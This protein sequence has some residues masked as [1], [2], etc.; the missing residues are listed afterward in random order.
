MLGSMFA[1]LTPMALARANDGALLYRCF[2]TVHS[3][4][5]SSID[6]SCEG[7]SKNGTLGC[8]HA[9]GEIP[10]VRC[11][12]GKD[13]LCAER[14]CDKGY[15]QETV[16]GNLYDMAPAADGIRLYRCRIS[17]GLFRLV[18]PEKDIVITSRQVNLRS[19]R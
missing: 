5:F 18:R 3:D 19:Y 11:F 14:A 17:V 13:H 9:D 15:T 1:A 8:M 6:P 4:H 16:L 10:L 7:K 2:D 12:D